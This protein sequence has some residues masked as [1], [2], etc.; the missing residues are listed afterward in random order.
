LKIHDPITNK[1]FYGRW[2]KYLE[3]NFG[4][5]ITYEEVTCIKKCID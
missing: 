5:N 3:E 1:I 2:K 4:N